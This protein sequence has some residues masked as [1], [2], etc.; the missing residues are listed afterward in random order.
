MLSNSLQPSAKKHGK[1]AHPFDLGG[2]IEGEG[3]ID[4]VSD[5]KTA[6]IEDELLDDISEEEEANQSW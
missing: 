2:V 6:E 3:E 5:D 4:T 1:N